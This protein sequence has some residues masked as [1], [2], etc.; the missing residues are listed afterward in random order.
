MEISNQLI[1]Q[2]FISLI[3]PCIRPNVF[4]VVVHILK[5][6]Q[7]HEL[8]HKILGRIPKVFHQIENSLG[9]ATNDISVRD[10]Q[11]L[12]DIVSALMV[13]FPVNNNIYNEIV[14]ISDTNCL[15]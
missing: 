13:K 14:S 10:L 2:L 3:I 15:L 6:A 8:F 11:L 1:E 4:P 12:V 5:S 9:T 7:S